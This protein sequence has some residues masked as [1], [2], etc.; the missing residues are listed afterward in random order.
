MGPRRRYSGTCRGHVQEW[1]TRPSTQKCTT[2]TVTFF[3]GRGQKKTT[4][5]G[6]LGAP[7]IPTLRGSVFHRP[8]TPQPASRSVAM[9]LDIYNLTDRTLVCHWNLESPQE[10]HILLPNLPMSVQIPS[11]C[12]MMTVTARQSM[13]QRG[14]K[15]GIWLSTTSFS[16]KRR[17]NAL[18]TVMKVD[19]FAPWMVY[20]SR[21]SCG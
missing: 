3:A 9:K 18:W 13:G 21:V 19:E 10:Y 16:F 11:R 15:D 4:K 14:P 17:R 6:V 2:A 5:P 7:G 12:S 8:R 20:R 1:V